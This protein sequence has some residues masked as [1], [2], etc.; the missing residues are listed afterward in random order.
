MF[1]HTPLIFLDDEN[2]DAEEIVL[3]DIY[4]EEYYQAFLQLV[5]LLSAL[6]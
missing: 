4:I 3:F 2:D 1:V 5:L 6:E